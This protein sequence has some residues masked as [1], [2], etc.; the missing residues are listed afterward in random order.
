M[1]VRTLFAQKA[2]LQP[3]FELQFEN[4]SCHSKCLFRISAQNKKNSSPVR[5][6]HL[7]SKHVRHILHDPLT[8]A[9]I[10]TGHFGSDM[11]AAVST[12]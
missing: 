8:V 6:F 3:C 4:T 2:F 12:F 9:E 11:H 10:L 7:H 1:Q 5:S